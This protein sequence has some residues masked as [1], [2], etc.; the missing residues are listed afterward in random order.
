MI[1]ELPKLSV[2]VLTFSRPSEI[3]NNITQLLT[4][5]Y[6][7]LEIVVVDNASEIPVS[8]I[9]P[10]D[11]RVKIIILEENVGVAGRNVGISAASGEIIITLDDD[12]TGIT[13][14]SI[15]KIL[16]L[17]EKPDIAAINFKVLDEKTGEITNWC[18][19]RMQEIYSDISFDTYE[20][21]EGAVAFKKN[22][23]VQA[24]M[25]PSLFFISHEGPDLAIRIMDL[26]YRVIFTPEIIVKHS[27]CQVARV[28]WRR[29][30]YDTRN[31][32]WLV[33]RSFPILTGARILIMDI[34]PMFIYSIRDGYFKYWLKG[35]YDA[36]LKLKEVIKSRKK[37][38]KKTHR[39]YKE[40]SS[41][42]PSVFYILK[43][44]LFKKNVSI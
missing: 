30:Y 32:V 38:S 7:D 34:G 17:F 33:T 10:E 29:Y 31:A 23:I 15:D 11:P 6:K 28:D 2:V 8:S 9:L 44:R 39:A 13:D 14:D 41:Y 37:I 25:Y 40:I 19:H 3:L 21:S 26:G 12:V 4:L 22:I 20:I 18:H 42:N 43:R 24:G 27:H 1:S 5:T 16:E 36:V 35:V